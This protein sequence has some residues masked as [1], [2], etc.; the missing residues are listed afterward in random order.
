MNKL[1]KRL[2]TG[3]LTLAI[4]MP[5]LWAQAGAQEEEPIIEFHTNVY[6]LYQEN[7]A[8]HFHIGATEETYIEVDCGFGKVEVEV[9]QAVYD[10]DTEDISATVVSCE[11]NETGIVKIYGDASLIDYL[12]FEGCYISEIKWPTVTE[13]QVLNLCHNELESLDLSHMTKLEALY[14]DDN[15]MTVS[16]M[17]IGANKPNLAILSASLVG[18]MD[19]SFDISNYPELRSLTAFSTPS[20]SR[21]DP[22]GCPKLLQ[23]SLD[24]ASISSIDVSK[25]PYLLILNVSDT[26]VHNLDLSGNPILR[27]LYCSHN[28]A[29]NNESKFTSLDLSKT[30]DLLRLFIAGNAFE[31]LDLSPVAKLQSLSASHNQLTTLNIDSNPEIFEL[32]LS[33]NN[34]DFVTLPADRSSFI[35]YSYAQR[36]FQVETQY[37][38]GSVLDFSAR[39]NRPGSTTSAVLYGYKE[40]APSDPRIIDEDSYS[41][42]NGKLTLLGAQADSVYVAFKNTALPDAILTTT[43]FAVKS[44]E[45]FGQPSAA[46][47]MRMM[48]TLRNYAFSVG[49]AGASAE[50]PRTFYVDFGNGQQVACTATS[51]GLPATA[52]VVGAKPTGGNSTITIYLPDGEQLTAL[53]VA[54][55]RI[56]SLDIEQARALQYL[57]IT[58]CLLPQIDLSWNRS[59]KAVDLSGNN[60]TEIEFTAPTGAYTKVA[61]SDVNLSDNKLTSIIFEEPRT[62][63]SA[64]FS[65]NQLADATLEK[66]ANVKS[67]NLSGNL[68]TEV[69]LRDLEA[70]ETL[71]LSDNNLT[72]LTLLDYLPLTRL[73]VSKNNLTFAALPAPGVVSD[74]VYAPQKEIVQP[75]KAPVVSLYNYLFDSE[76]GSTEFA[77]YMADTNTPVAEGNIRENN[78]RFFFTNPDLGNVYCTLSNPAFPAFTG[79]D[80]LRTSV[81]E[82]AA[83]P[84]HV[85]ASFTPTADGTGELILG[86]HEAGAAVYV[87]WTGEG[88][89]EQYI[90]PKDYQVYQGH[91]M[92]GKEGK[93]YTY[94]END[95]VRVFSIGGM[96]LSSIDASPMKGLVAFMADSGNL[97]IANIQLPT[98]SKL[99]EL[100]L[101]G[102]NFESTDFLKIFPTLAHL[103]LN[104]DGLGTP[105]VSG[106]KALETLY[107]LSSGL[108]DI[109][110]GNPVLWDL[111]LSGNEFET[112]DLSGVPGVKQLY[113][114]D[115][116]LTQLDL[117]GL[118]ALQV[119][120]IEGNKLTF[121]TLPIR[122]GTWTTYGYT[123]QAIIPI[124]VTDGKVDLSS[125]AMVHGVATEYHWF[126]DTPYLDDNG[127]LAG[128][129]LVEGEEYTIENGVT[130]FLTS[131][132]YVMCVMT[133]ELFPNLYQ[134]TSFV[135]VEISGIENVSIEDAAQGETEWYNLQGIRV[136]EPTRGIYI[137]RQGTQSTKVYVR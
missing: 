127:D 71:D 72:S 25:N 31:T 61:L 22:T 115:N 9:G 118:K 35:D 107:I 3:L 77:W 131:Q 83:M 92:A 114:I 21:I 102:I 67:L 37:A 111:N 129:E 42:D 4:G 113:L 15:P 112:I 74:Y 110:L 119:V 16:P 7:N 30:P 136:A 88:D 116:E 56:L 60:L 91:V 104:G 134:L 128:E 120:N 87:D 97:D 108:T 90:L 32:D 41:W 17:V 86:A 121:S 55:Q 117:S 48:P 5:G 51:N 20:I 36:P 19:P 18:N 10:P 73:N 82:T 89:M 123:G 44:A 99:E 38:V 1:I 105:D 34:M 46:A 33:M 125:E 63:L 26:K 106:L 50:N 45:D 53:G 57:S 28:G 14:V 62:L 79:A 132:E 24:G 133:N 76:A 98:E 47:S 78:G 135:D 52:N 95:G 94:D 29:Y 59:L 54:D 96:E 65:N 109:K 69:D 68:L 6:D 8:F 58:G 103:T 2:G 122:Q 84:T 130:T 49:L 23:L 40:D 124:E 75:E 27:E 39:V 80:I 70:I 11:A 13:L 85:F 126:I 100:R 66:M 12:D 64:D 101:T 137:R 81:V 43:K 93:C